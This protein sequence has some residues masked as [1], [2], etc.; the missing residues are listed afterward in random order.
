[1]TWM[2]ALAHRA[3][4]VMALDGHTSRRSRDR[5][6][7]S[8][9]LHVVR[10]W[11][12][13]HALVLAQVTGDDQSHASTALPERLARL[14]RHGRGVTREAM[15]GQGERARQL[16]DHGG[17]SV[18]RVQEHQPRVHRDGDELCE[19][20]K[21]PHPRD[22]EGVLGDDAQVDGGHGRLETRQ[23]WSTAAREGLGAWARWPGLTTWVLVAST[24]QVSNQGRRARRYDISALP[25]PTDDEAKPWSR[26]IRPPW[27]LANRVHGVL[28]VAMGEETHRPRAGERAQHLA[29]IRTLA[30]HLL[31]RETSVQVGIAANQTRAGWDHNYRRKMLAQT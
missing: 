26:V 11:A 7:G 2:R 27:E 10:A 9:A 25:G 21:G 18:V 30:L 1:M 28:A 6:D 31:R 14:T 4:E 23:V 24:R 12:S 15:G 17:D 5:A 8:G 3:E 29:F 13:R 20:L 19:W 16:V 22:Q